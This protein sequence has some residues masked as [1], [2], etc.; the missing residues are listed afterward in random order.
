MRAG[1]DI[2]PEDRRRTRAWVA[3][4]LPPRAPAFLAVLALSVVAAGLG[5]W[6][7]MLTRALIDDALPSGH[8]APVMRICGMI[9][10]LAVFSTG[11][12]FV[13]R[14]FYVRVS[15]GLL[16]DLR[17]ALF[18]H[19]MSLSPRWFAHARE[20]DI[21]SRLD[22]DISEVQRFV[23][24]GA[25]A[26]VTALITLVGATLAMASL[27]APLTAI[28]FLGLPLQII[29]LAKLRPRIEQQAR[30]LRARAADL[31][32]FFFETL[33]AIRHIQACSAEPVEGGRLKRLNGAYLDELI[34]QE[35]LSFLAGAAPSLVMSAMT[36]LIF[37]FGAATLLGQPMTIGGM[38]A[39][40]SYLGRASGPLQS[41]L[42]L[43][44]GAKRT[45][46]SLD[47]L[48]ELLLVAPEVREAPQ[49]RSLPSFPR[50]EV[51]ARELGLR[52]GA[53]RIFSGLSFTLAAGERVA[54]TGPSGAGKSS[55][56][57]L[58]M[59]F[60]D[61][62]EGGLT[63]DGVAL[64]EAPLGE[65]RQAVVMVSQDIALTPG[66]LFEN[67]A[68]GLPD[69]PRAA[70]ERALAAAGLGDFVASLPQGKDTPVGGRG[71]ALSGGQRQ[72]LAIA[73]AL[74]TSPRLLI[75]DEVTTGLESELSDRIFDTI[76]LLFPTTTLLI[77]SHDPR[78]VARCSRVITLAAEGGGREGR[79]D[80][81]PPRAEPER[82]RDARYSL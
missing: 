27:N 16:F 11:L 2:S 46:A 56:C 38:V 4:F 48:G 33:P 29:L 60:Y 26:F 24:D 8:L 36:A 10:A 62:D 34:R 23:F 15:G 82:D 59:R 67:V 57:D 52:H 14:L 81:R 73:R 78:V 70:A 40:S 58:L 47:R 65:L 12:S 21:F 72:R 51:V 32:A 75:L 30:R 13:T 5:L 22:G 1:P 74:A 50:G 28:C 79:A 66:S 53:R 54:L 61:P 17:E 69:L 25:L 31:G 76:D 6:Q 71:L 63:L 41:L 68:Y 49:T 19:L 39:F 45:T 77:V 9:F 35:K 43:W 3:G 64:T 18:A 80:G 37:V 44:V 7:P 42:G 20:G 55:L